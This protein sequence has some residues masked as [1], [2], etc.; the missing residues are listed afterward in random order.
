MTGILKDRRVSLRLP[1]PTRVLDGVRP[2]DRYRLQIPGTTGFHEREFMAAGHVVCVIPY[3]P[4]RDEVVLIRQFRLAAHVRTGKGEMIEVPAGRVDPGEEADAAARRELLEE[5]G[6]VAARLLKGPSVMPSPGSTA[7]LYHLY[8][9]EVA[10]GA[11]AANAGLAHE[12]EVIRPI[13]VPALRAIYAARRGA[14]V[15]GYAL[16]ALTWFAAKRPKVRRAWATPA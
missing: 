8:V 16:M 13:P 1:T 7:E 14:F 5:T 12:G 4:V 15:N 11:A 6:L 10:A 3:D 9:A 2:V